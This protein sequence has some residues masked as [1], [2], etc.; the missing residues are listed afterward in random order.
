MSVLRIW[1]LLYRSK[2]SSIYIFYL[3]NVSTYCTTVP[4]YTS[5]V[6][7]QEQKQNSS[8]R[9][10]L[11]LVLLT[12]IFIACK[13]RISFKILDAHCCVRARVQL[14]RKNNN[15]KK[16]RIF[17]NDAVEGKT[18]ECLKRVESSVHSSSAAFAGAWSVGWEQ[19]SSKVQSNMTPG[20]PL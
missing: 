7:Q 4:A 9:F 3:S 5:L 18:F 20:N 13:Y 11:H 15:T 19:F 17:R 2:L 10:L 14:K 8:S 1:Y 6:S 12:L 16:G